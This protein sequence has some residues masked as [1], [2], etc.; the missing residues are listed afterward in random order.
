VSGHDDDEV[1]DAVVAL[2]ESGEYL[3]QIPGRPGE[4]VDG[5]GALQLGPGDVRSRVYHRDSDEYRQAKAAGLVEGLPVPPRP[6]ASSAAVEEA[7]VAVGHPLPPLLRRLYLEVSN[8]GFGPG[9]GIL[10]L[11]GGHSEPPD[12]TA[13]DRYLAWRDAKRSLVSSPEL[14]PVCDWGC[15]ILSLV[16]CSDGQAQMWGFDPNP[17]EDLDQA[18]FAEGMTFTEWLGQWVDG[19]CIQP[20]AVQDP[21]TGAWGGAAAIARRRPKGH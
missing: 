17:V 20:H 18:V 21:A 4:A 8:G 15:A 7:E 12:G 16:D 2:I 19:V 6:P 5:G 13:M 10:G 11:R 14:F 9:Y 3:D 1:F